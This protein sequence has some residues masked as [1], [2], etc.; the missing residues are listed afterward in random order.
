MEQIFRPFFTTKSEVK[1]TGLGLS[2][3]YGIIKKHHGE[4]RVESQPGNGATFTILLP[5]D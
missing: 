3:S 2:I 4:I 1:G 5:I